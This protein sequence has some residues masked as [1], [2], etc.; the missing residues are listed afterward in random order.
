MFYSNPA[1]GYWKLFANATDR[2]RQGIEVYSIAKVIWCIFEETTNEFGI[3]ELSPEEL[4]AKKG[5]G[6]P[7]IDTVFP[8]FTKTPVA[9]RHWI[10][11]CKA[12]NGAMLSANAMQMCLKSVARQAL[13][14]RCTG[15]MAM[16]HQA[17]LIPTSSLRAGL[18]II[19]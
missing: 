13:A 19:I 15:F 17:S 5:D 1:R 11:L 7:L 9:F 18:R 2:E 14:R 6:T 3:A 10:W 16:L 4:Q 8:H 12:L